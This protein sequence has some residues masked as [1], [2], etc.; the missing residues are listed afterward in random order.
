M[1]NVPTP[2]HACPPSGS[3]LACLLVIGLFAG[4]CSFWQQKSDS[5]PPPPARKT[6]R[7]APPAR[8]LTLAESPVLSVLHFENRTRRAELGWLRKALAD[9]LIAELGRRPT[10]TVVQRERVD[11]VLHQTSLRPSGRPGDATTLRIGRLLGATELVV[12]HFGVTRNRLRVEAYLL[13]VT[14]GTV[15]GTLSTEST[16]TESP[17][18]AQAVVRQLLAL[19]H[20]ADPR[21][22]PRPMVGRHFLQAAKAN[23]RG[24]DLWEQGRRTQA[25]R[26]FEQALAVDHTYRT[27]YSNY[28]AALQALS[29]WDLLE[30]ERKGK[31]PLTDDQVVRRVVARLVGSGFEAELGTSRV[32]A[33]KDG[34]R[35]LIVPVRVS[36]NPS[37]L[38]AVF[39]SLGNFGGRIEPGVTGEGPVEVTLSGRPRLNTTFVEQLRQPWR[40]YLHLVTRTGYSIGVYSD[41]RDGLVRNWILP[42][43]H[44]RLR[45]DQHKTL[46][47]DAR[48]TGLS[49]EHIGQIAAVKISTKPVPGE[50]TAVR[51]AV[52]R[53]RSLTSRRGSGSR[54][55]SA[56]QSESRNGQDQYVTTVQSKLPTLQTAIA[57]L[58]NPPIAAGPGTKSPKGLTKGQALVDLGLREGDVGFR[59]KPTIIRTSGD[60]AVD[61]SCRSAT[62]VAA[63][64]WAEE[65]TYTVVMPLWPAQTHRPSN[66]T[67]GT[68]SAL[69]RILIQCQLT[70]DLPVFNFIDAQRFTTPLGQGTSPPHIRR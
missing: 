30:F 65:L 67:N 48:F 17:A 9:L 60:P 22:N 53:T 49:R 15:L 16:L 12:G 54:P 37:A 24:E 62:Q 32:E 34:T 61:D 20:R 47:F 11:E 43:D 52:G 1:T 7:E 31:S 28:S 6:V 4:S 57:R 50:R 33:A 14:D 10:L 55:L 63:E 51:V 2:H 45:I 66:G 21:I 46:A 69:P 39:E 29:G 26:A 64:N 70:K 8:S 56:V 3:L 35:T 23:A 42:L 5:A 41:H 38:E 25:V 13:R 68:S 36:L 18:L 59:V 19:L 44:E 40:I 27:A 58:W